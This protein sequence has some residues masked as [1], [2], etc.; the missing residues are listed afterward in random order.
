[1]RSGGV[2]VRV[3]GNGAKVAAAADVALRSTGGVPGVNGVAVAVAMT[4]GVTSGVCVAEG[5]EVGVSAAVGAVV[6]VAVAGALVAAVVGA[7]S[8]TVAAGSVAGEQASRTNGHISARSKDGLFI[9]GA[10]FV[11]VQQRA[12]GASPREVACALE[13]AL[14]K[15]T[16]QCCIIKRA[17]KRVGECIGV[18][19]RAS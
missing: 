8:T 3:A 19:R 9:S 17:A 13:A 7:S 6:G 2:A 15:V 5:M 16:T 4:V 12:R 11:H 14:A 18:V 10:T 1:M